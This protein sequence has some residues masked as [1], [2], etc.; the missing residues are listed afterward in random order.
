MIKSSL[1][2][3]EDDK[4]LSESYCEFFEAKGYEIVGIAFNG[5]EAIE[6]LKT[7]KP[8]FIILD[9]LM[10]DYDGYYLIKQLRNFKNIPKIIVVTGCGDCNY[11][12]DVATVF[13]KPISVHKIE[14]FIQNLKN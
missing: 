3:V 1:M 8:D 9:T 6:I 5:L 2:I 7:K 13:K 4:D 10:Q 11:G 14:E 12:D